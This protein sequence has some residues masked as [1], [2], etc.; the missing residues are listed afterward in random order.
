[1]P[2]DRSQPSIP[3]RPWKFQSPFPIEGNGT[4]AKPHP[5]PSP[6]SLLQSPSFNS[7]IL[8]FSCLN[9]AAT[10]SPAARRSSPGSLDSLVTSPGWEQG[11]W[12]G[13]DSPGRWR[14]AGAPGC[15]AA[16]FWLDT[17]ACE[18]G[19]AG[20]GAGG[21][22]VAQRARPAASKPR[23]AAL[24]AGWQG[25]PAPASTP[26]SSPGSSPAPSSPQAP[27]P[28]AGRARWPIP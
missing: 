26:G 3:A 10:P 13:R 12:P 17:G 1:M 5:G 4:L 9:T 11:R 27:P 8:A 7:A 15:P 20:G 25:K 23:A 28:P 18:G 19:S 14:S 22:R 16:A 24:A 21:K 2:G 6:N